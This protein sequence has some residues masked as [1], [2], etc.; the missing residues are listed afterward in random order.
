ML[1]PHLDQRVHRFKLSRAQESRRWPEWLVMS[2]WYG[3]AYE[4][5]SM[6][7]QGEHQFVLSLDGPHSPYETL[8]RFECSYLNQDLYARLDPSFA[9]QFQCMDFSIHRLRERR[10]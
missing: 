5:G 10:E 9:H 8:A 3:R 4:R 7:R 6:I 2:G 1:D